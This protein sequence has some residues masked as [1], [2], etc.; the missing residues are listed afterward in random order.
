MLRAHLHDRARLGVGEAPASRD[1][2]VSSQENVVCWMRK[3][4]GCLS[5]EE[6]HTRRRG[7]LLRCVARDGGVVGHNSLDII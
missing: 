2:G 4:L 6:L 7:I 3:L 5:E 1:G